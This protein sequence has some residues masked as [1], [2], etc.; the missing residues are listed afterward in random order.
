MGTVRRPTAEGS[1]VAL[2]N[3]AVKPRY[4]DGHVGVITRKEFDRCVVRLDEPVGRYADGEVKAR[5]SSLMKIGP[6]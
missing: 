5:A 4:L 6:E 2:V 3:D 1:E